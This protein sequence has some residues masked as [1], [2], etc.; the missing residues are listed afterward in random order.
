MAEGEGSLI[1][2]I[3]LCNSTMHEFP[4][5]NGVCSHL[6]RQKRAKMENSTIMLRAK[7]ETIYRKLEPLLF[8]KERATQA[9]KRTVTDF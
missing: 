4:A 3:V 9:K 7:F 6:P 2:L 5:L 1:L 8:Y